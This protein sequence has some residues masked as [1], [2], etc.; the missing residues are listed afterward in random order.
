M[1]HKLGFT[2]VYEVERA[3]EVLREAVWDYQ[4]EYVDEYPIISSFCPAIV[5]LIQV[6]FPSLVD[7][8]M[9]LNTPSDIAATFY[10]KKLTDQGLRRNNFV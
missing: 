1:L 3:V 7:Q 2:H 10:R 4:K 8:I 5:R 6:K 9:K